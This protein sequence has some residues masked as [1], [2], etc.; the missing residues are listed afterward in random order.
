MRPFRLLPIA[1]AGLFAAAPAASADTARSS[2]AFVNSIG[3]NTHVIYDDTAYGNFPLVRDRLKEL[4]VRNVRDGLCGSCAWQHD[5]LNALAAAGIKADLIVGDPR[6]RTGTLSENLAAVKAK[7]MSSVSALEAPNEW[8]LFSGWS[9]TWTGD[10]RTYQ[11]SLYAAVSADP[12]L[13]N[14]PVVG[15]SLV[16]SA[17][18]DQLGSLA[19]HLDRGNMH[20]YAGGRPPESNVPSELSLAAKVSGEKAV[21]ATEAGYHNATGQAN[22]D[23]PGVDEATAARYLPRM[24]LEYFRSGI[25]RTYAYELLDERPGK[26]SYDMEQSFGLLR[27]DFSRKPSFNAIRNLIAVLADPGPAVPSAEVPVTV[28][29]GPSDLRRLVLRKRDGRVYVALWRAV[30]R[31]NQTARTTTSV[32]AAPATVKFGMAVKSVGAISPVDSTA[33]TAL[34][35]SGGAVTVSLVSAPIILQV[36]PAVATTAQANPPEAG[37][38]TASAPVA[39]AAAPAPPVQSTAAPVAQ[40]VPASAAPSVAAAPRTAK[41]SARKAAE[42]KRSSAARKRK[43]AKR[44]RLAR[45]RAAARRRAVSRH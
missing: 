36:T 13:R 7:L 17:S 30:S 38:P 28:T 44:K 39:T 22:N 34:P 35:V 8:D 41:T 18:R 14:V 3:V 33:A 29:Q 20:S 45:R 15:P 37:A 25:S 9:S 16:G 19:T 31:W 10:L 11:Q 24:F 1:L 27:S 42:R 21:M 23:H 32:S 12:A 43:A 6:S 4:G 2:D 5:R 26:A 40:P